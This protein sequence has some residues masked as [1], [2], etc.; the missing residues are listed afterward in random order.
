MDHLTFESLIY[1][2]YEH[3]YV[4]L[5]MLVLGEG[6][7]QS[8]AH[9]KVIIPTGCVN[10]NGYILTQGIIWHLAGL[11]P[12]RKEAFFFFLVERAN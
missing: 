3:F 12:V 6:S 11:C 8:L 5:D 4:V 2:A 10:G 9:G 7:V 1:T